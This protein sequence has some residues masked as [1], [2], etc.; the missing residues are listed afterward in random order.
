M[1]G[2]ALGQRLTHWRLSMLEDAAP[3]AATL[4]RELAG[5]IDGEVRF[6]DG[7][8]A[9]YST[10]ASN[11]RQVPIGVVIPRT[12]EDLVRTV[13]ICR[14]HGVPVVSRGGGTSLAGQTC[15]A[16]VVI[17]CSKYLT[18]LRD[19]DVAGRRATVEP[20]IILDTLR[21][22]AERFH[23]TL[24]PDPATHDRC[25][26]GGMIGNNACGVHAHMAGR[27]AENVEELEILTYDGLRMR[28]GPTTEEALDRIIA[29]GGRRGQIYAGLKRLRDTY[30]DRL[31]SFP[32]LPRL[33]SGYGLQYLLPEHG[34]NV[35]RA[36]VGTEGT[37]VTILEATVKLIYSYPARV[38]VVLGYPD[39]YQAGDH[40]ALI[41]RF[42]PIGLEG[43]DQLL[44]A[45]MRK[46]GL[47][48]AHLPMLPEGQGHLIV[49]FGGADVAEARGKAERMIA[50]LE[51]APDAPTMVMYDAEH[52]QKKIWNIRE[53]GLGATAFVPGEPDTWPGWE[54]SAVPPDRVGDY[55]RAL[56]RL[57]DQ[58]D[59]HPSLYGHFG[60]GCIHCRVN[61]DLQSASGIATFRAFLDEAAELVV[62]FGGSLSGEH[63]DGQARAELLPK[64]FGP[65]IMQAFRE[66]KALWD[67]EGKMNPGKVVD[68][69]PI[70]ANLRLGTDYQPRQVETHFQYPDDG[71]SFAHATTRCVGVGKCRRLGGEGT[72]CPSYMVTRDEADTTRGRAR[73]LFE[74][75]REGAI[76]DGWKSEAV[77]E[78]LDL[79]LACKGCKTDCPVNVDMATYKA[80]FFSHYYEGRLRPRPAY[81]LGLIDV[82][83]R[84]AAYVPNLANLVT[85]TP[86]LKRLV[87]GVAGL[88]TERDMPPFAPETFKAW[89]LRRAPANVGAR[90]VILW[91]DTFNNHFHPEVAKSA[92]TVLEAAGF[93]VTVPEQA[94]C[95]GRPLYD[96]GMLDRAKAYLQQVLGALREEI[97]AGVAVVGLEPSCVSVFREELCNLFPHDED[98]KRLRDQSY[99]LD[100]F[101]AQEAPDWRPPRL[102]RRAIVHM[103]CHHKSIMGTGAQT[104]VLDRLGLD[105]EVLDSGC[106]GLAG[107]FGYE[108]GE[109]YEVAQ[110]AGERVLWPAV[111]QADPE[112]LVLTDGFSC[113]TQI[114]QG[115][116][117]RALHLAEVLAMAIEGAPARPGRTRLT[118]TERALAGLAA[119]GLAAW[120]IGR[121]RA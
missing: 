37:C 66:F 3:E 36:L 13:T 43:M 5:A 1:N 48:E 109:K 98:A 6:D 97:R 117:R 42:E 52:D 84:L 76:Q 113:H 89:F 8:K 34:M 73:A 65:E 46:K 61:F 104:A 40:V 26:V 78:T 103:H 111:R 70:T 96:F 105:Y 58:Y 75:M 9:L 90:R 86:G 63:G 94:L 110:L 83:S 115:T 106:C 27:M 68:P 2:K 81:A 67:P 33:V 31:R 38:L 80:E 25:T 85:Q 15:N 101:L 95:C 17:D 22:A 57:F 87:M 44:P 35:A 21:Q 12:V 28:V 7:A 107:S 23:L 4:A 102:S 59:Y 77:K 16:A 32:A 82:W 79:C 56:R 50:A 29:E 55:M 93:H 18:A 49:E 30:A 100:E 120:L 24:G 71:G 121:R 54:D 116:G 53:S 112:T 20:G 62:G 118:G 88:A 119:A 72:M 10:D 47:H 69:D 99:Q 39:V 11:Y 74:M 92:V 60:Q 114:A 91:P 45:Y 64:M 108:A 14:R 19:L 41:D 51:A